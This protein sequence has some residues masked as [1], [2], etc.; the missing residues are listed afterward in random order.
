MYTWTCICIWK[1]V[2]KKQT[3]PVTFLFPSDDSFR[4]VLYVQESVGTSVTTILECYPVFSFLFF[5]TLWSI[6]NILLIQ[7]SFKNLLFIIQFHLGNVV[8]AY[9]SLLWPPSTFVYKHMKPHDN[10]NLDIMLLE[11]GSHAF[12][13]A[14]NAVSL[15][16]QQ[17]HPAFL[18]NEFETSFKTF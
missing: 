11:I 17:C 15:T 12:Q 5:S 4:T 9:H 1:D 6:E 14:C 10:R 8:I 16:L 2:K 3:F 18:G 13:L 7:Y